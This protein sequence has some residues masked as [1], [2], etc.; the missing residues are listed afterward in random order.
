MLIAALLQDISHL[1][2]AIFT[3]C[4]WLVLIGFLISMWQALLQGWANLQRLHQVPCSNCTFFTGE[5]NLKCTLYPCKAL[6]EEAINCQDYQPVIP[7]E[8]PLLAR[9]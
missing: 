1:A 8:E 4:I 5:Y 9:R 2:R 6:T 7:D 3:I